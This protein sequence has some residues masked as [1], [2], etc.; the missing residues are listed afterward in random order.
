MEGHLG[1]RT[2]DV[3]GRFDRSSIGVERYA[4][5]LGHRRTWRGRENSHNFEAGDAATLGLLFQPE[6][7]EHSPAL[8]HVPCLLAAGAARPGGSGGGRG[9]GVGGSNGQHERKAGPNNRGGDLRDS[10]FFSS[11]HIASFWG[12]PPRC[13]D[14]HHWHQAHSHRHQ[15]QCLTV[16]AGSSTGGLRRPTAGGPPPYAA[17]TLASVTQSRSGD[18]AVREGFQRWSDVVNG[19]IPT[20]LSSPR[21]EDFRA[22]VRALELGPLWATVQ[23]A[24]TVHSRRTNA[25]IR[26]LDP[27]SWLLTLVTHGRLGIDQYGSRALL[28]AGDLMVVDTSHPY[29]MWAQAT[30]QAGTVMVN[31]PRNMLSIPDHAMRSLAAR[32]FPSDRGVGGILRGLLHHVAEADRAW[33]VLEANH[34]GSA[35]ADLTAAF[36]AQLTRTQGGLSAPTRQAVLV[37]EIRAFI[38][39][40]LSDNRL[41]PAAVAAAHNI[42]L[43]YLHLLLHADGETVQA[44][45]RARR[46]EHC[47]TDLRRTDR[48]V[49][50]VGARWGFPDPTTFSRA[51]KRAFG[52]PPGEYRRRYSVEPE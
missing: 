52:L 25:T 41:T 47:R 46:L 19:F 27:Q 20:V 30:D 35:V 6:A 31:L 3:V 49:A 17:G 5:D 8:P 13:C 51:F 12:Q 23:A 42:S 40:N 44:L 1:E 18:L 50:A 29:H 22:S 26:R 37:H 16:R 7:Q 14:I 43:R 2:G 36:L 11:L 45:I 10:H 15:V 21:A 33:P 48:T 4:S 9:C 34:L 24:S 38:E 32:K 28:A 39:R